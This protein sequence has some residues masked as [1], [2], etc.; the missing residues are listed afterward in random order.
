MHSRLRRSRLSA[1][2]GTAA[3]SD[4]ASARQAA[5]VLALQRSA[6]NHAVV[7][8]LARQPETKTKPKV[9]TIQGERVE[10]ASDAEAKD[11]DR[12]LKLL[13]DTYGVTFDSAATRQAVRKDKTE[14]GVE[15]G[16]VEKIDIVPWTY[17]DLRDLEAGFKHYAPLL[18]QERAKSSRKGTPQ[19]VT[20]MGR[21]SHYDDDPE[22]QYLKDDS[23]IAIF[24]SHSKAVPD[25][26]EFTAVHEIA[27]AV[28]G[29]LVEDFRRTVGYWTTPTADRK[30]GKV[31][32]PPT[33]YGKKNPDE[34]LADSVALYFTARDFLRDGQRGKKRGEVG[35]KCPKRLAW[36]EAE[37]TRWKATDKPR[38]RRR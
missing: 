26:D 23:A 17:L 5:A 12:I 18:G 6:G 1:P 13:K 11:A 16:D 30:V 19:E 29:P 32:A 4:A 38:K 28:F 27:H 24:K 7:D 2:G 31:E 25:P 36:I 37:V 14:R 35:N 22:G 9:V 3:S 34:D 21:L 33:D 8:I 20:K 10:V 15:K